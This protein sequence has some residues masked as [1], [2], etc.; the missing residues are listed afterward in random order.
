MSTATSVPGLRWTAFEKTWVSDGE[1]NGYINPQLA[2][3]HDSSY[4]WLAWAFAGVFVVGLVELTASLVWAVRSRRAP[5]A[6]AD[7]AFNISDS[8]TV[9]DPYVPTADGIRFEQL[10]N[11]GALTE[12]EFQ[13][14]KRR[15]LNG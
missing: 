15:I 2:F 7:E 13:A 14:E 5:S 8:D 3:G 11:S 1:V 6:P 10:R 12:D 4:G 9:S